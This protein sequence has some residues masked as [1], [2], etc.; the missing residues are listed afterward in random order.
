MSNDSWARVP[1]NAGLSLKD[2]AQD[3]NINYNDFIDQL[4]ENKNDKDIADNLKVA[5]E[6][7][8]HLRQQFERFGLDSIQGQ[9]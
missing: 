7:V 5:E 4:K 8:Y 6:I 3:L 1:W 9:D 2:V